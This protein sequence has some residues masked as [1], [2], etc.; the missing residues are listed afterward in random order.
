MFDFIIWI[1]FLR[2]FSLMYLFFCIKMIV[3]YISKV[4]IIIEMYKEIV[5]DIEL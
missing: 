4:G 2:L 1:V 3:I 5:G